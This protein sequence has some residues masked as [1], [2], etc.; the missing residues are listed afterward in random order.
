MRGGGSITHPI[1]LGILAILIVPVRVIVIHCTRYSLR[2]FQ[3]Y[4]DLDL[5]QFLC[6]VGIYISTCNTGIVTLYW[7]YCF[8][9]YDT[10]TAGFGSLCTLIPSIRQPLQSKD[11]VI[12]ASGASRKGVFDGS[13]VSFAFFREA[14]SDDRG[15]CFSLLLVTTQ[16]RALQDREG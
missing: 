5:L 13:E 15:A 4:L 11:A 2:S 1:H 10:E 12:D 3:C 7:F 6:L 14:V 9:D 8:T 16:E